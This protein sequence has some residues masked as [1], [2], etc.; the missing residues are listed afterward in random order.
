MKYSAIVA[1]FAAVSAAPAA[2]S[3]T[4]STLTPTGTLNESASAITSITGSYALSIRTVSAS[5]SEGISLDKRDDLVN[6]IGDGQIQQQTAATTADVVNQIGDGQ[7][8][9]QSA[10]TAD[11]V[12]QIGD[13]QIQQQT[14]A[15]TADVVNQIGDGQ[16]QQQT[17][18]TAD[19]VNQIGDGQIQQQ[20]QQ[21]ATTADVVNQI[22]DG[23]IQQ[24]SKTADVVN[25]IGDGQI[26]QQTTAPNT[27][28]VVNQIGDGQ[29]QQQTTGPQ[30]ATV[31]NQIGD[32]QVQQQSVAAES[33]VPTHSVIN[34]ISDGQIQ[35]TGS[36]D[37]GSTEHY[38]EETCV[39]DDSLLI[40]IEDGE[41]RDSHGRVGAIVANRQFQFD[42]PPPQAGT[43]YA[44]GWSFVPAEVAGLGE[45]EADTKEGGFK[46]ALG[47][48]T[49]FYKCLS[50][51]FYNLYDASIGDQCSAIEIFLLKAVDC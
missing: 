49:T 11:V 6:Q 43:I 32:G 34:Q 37:S 14:A 46:L 5:V 39:A 15:T 21:T 31:A 45:T 48:Q 8:Q 40:S 22:G 10:T 28:S 42:G 19:V 29:I 25:Q 36:P 4:W 26:Q 30:T 33:V 41:L 12:N 9:Q 2:V 1:I 47:D 16:I 23:Q 50:G 17:A 44:A 3:N 24:Q 35:A 20:Q 13:G 18:K 51:D 27:A 7:I 38:F